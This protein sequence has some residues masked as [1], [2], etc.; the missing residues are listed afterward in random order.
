MPTAQFT[1]TAT[2]SSNANTGNPAGLTVSA[3]SLSRAATE[4]S[5]KDAQTGTLVLSAGE[6][7]T[8]YQPTDPSGS[9]PET[10]Y[11]Y[12]QTPAT[13]NSGSLS[14]I[15]TSGS[16]QVTIASLKA[17]DWM[18]MPLRTLN[19]VG[20]GPTSCSLKVTNTTAFEA[21]VYVLYAESG[22]IV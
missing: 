4:I 8:V 19:G 22:S 15:Y 9:I 2:I 13:G 1:A 18:Y 20:H 6:T 16:N 17:G 10:A 12:M 7:Q 5:N 21:T 3:L 11:V 14:V